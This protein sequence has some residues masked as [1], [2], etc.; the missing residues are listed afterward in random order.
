M[1]SAEW[2]E[3][4]GLLKLSR[5]CQVHAKPAILT[6]NPGLGWILTDVEDGVTLLH[7]HAGRDVCQ[8]P[9][10]SIKDGPGQI[11]DW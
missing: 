4:E 3:R 11:H 10:I 5:C 2:S 6:N 7:A 9:N 8:P 1:K